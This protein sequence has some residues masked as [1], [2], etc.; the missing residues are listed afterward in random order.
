M[1][2]IM[3]LS[4]IPPRDVRFMAF[5]GL[6]KIGHGV[7]YFVLAA[8]AARAAGRRRRVVAWSVAFG[9]ALAYGGALEVGQAFVNRNPN[10]WDWVA[11]GIGA[12][13]G[14]ALVVKATDDH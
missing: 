8:L 13:A 5:A 12:A 11:D 4:T 14:A 7:F 6:D 1:I 10:L 2:V 9:L 3:A